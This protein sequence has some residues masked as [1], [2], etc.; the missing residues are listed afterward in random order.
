VFGCVQLVIHEID[1]AA[2]TPL[3]AVKLLALYLSSPENKVP[4]CW[5]RCCFLPSF[6]I[7]L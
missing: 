6:L 2:A 7:F 3:Q 5:I 1:D 4:F